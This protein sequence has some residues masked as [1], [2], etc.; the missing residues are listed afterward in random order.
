VAG[1]DLHE[2]LV[3]TLRGGCQPDERPAMTVYEAGYEPDPINLPRC[4]Q[5]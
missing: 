4:L 3:N 1:S 2:Q 5:E